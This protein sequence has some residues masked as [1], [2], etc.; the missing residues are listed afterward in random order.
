M[1][2]LCTHRC[3]L[4]ANL[5]PAPA[6]SARRWLIK[7]C[8]Y[9]QISPQWLGGCCSMWPWKV[10]ESVPAAY[11]WRKGPADRRALGEHVGIRYPAQR[12]LSRV[13]S[14]FCLQRAWTKVKE[15]INLSWGVSEVCGPHF[16][17]VD[18][19]TV[20][21]FPAPVTF[22]W[23]SASIVEPNSDRTPHFY[24]DFSLNLILFLLFY[25]PDGP[26]QWSGVHRVFDRC[27]FRYLLLAFGATPILPFSWCMF[28]RSVSASVRYLGQ[29]VGHGESVL[30]KLKYKPSKNIL[31][32]ELR[33]CSC[34]PPG[35]HRGSCCWSV[36][37]W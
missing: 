11:G 34:P 31:L 35:Y 15:R 2:L 37:L 29:V 13:T 32:L 16:V 18:W 27:S 12:Y 17:G 21:F 23:T 36:G 5:V 4:W 6:H 7:S 19:R 20:F 9:G 25:R 1:A 8:R 28:V 26:R 33:L 30:C 24:P 14:K 22:S 3:A 10:L